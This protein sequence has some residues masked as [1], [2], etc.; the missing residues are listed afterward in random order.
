MPKQNR[1]SIHYFMTKALTDGDIDLAVYQDD[2]FLHEVRIVAAESILAILQKIHS[3]QVHAR[4]HKRQLKFADLINT[5]HPITGLNMLDYCLVS[6]LGNLAQQLMRHGAVSTH[7]QSFSRKISR[8]FSNEE[9][10]PE[11]LQDVFTIVDSF[12]KIKRRVDDLVATTNEAAPGCVNAAQSLWTKKSNPIVWLSVG[13]GCAV[14]GPHLYPLVHHASSALV[15]SAVGVPALVTAAQ[16][17]QTPNTQTQVSEEMFIKDLIN[18]TKQIRHEL[19]QHSVVAE[20][21]VHGRRKHNVAK[22]RQNNLL[23]HFTE[24]KPQVSE[25]A[26]SNIQLGM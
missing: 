5:P 25:V 1:D 9:M 19:Q 2:A 4:K 12:V 17:S 15:L 6:G 22:D 7:M 14:L 16:S 21:R 18:S 24:A 8:T 11:I 26:R 3:E 23:H 13:I 10:Q 20:R